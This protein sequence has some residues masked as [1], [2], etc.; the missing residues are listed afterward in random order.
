MVFLKFVKFQAWPVSP[1]SGVLLVV[2][3]PRRIL[4]QN[5]KGIEGFGM[6]AR[7]SEICSEFARKVAWSKG[8][9]RWWP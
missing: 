1:A 9:V 2:S 6:L 5:D 7:N 3:H 4:A 8:D